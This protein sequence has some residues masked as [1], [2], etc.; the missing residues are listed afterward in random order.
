MVKEGCL[1]GIEEVYGFHNSPMFDEGF[2]KVKSGA[3]LASSSTVQ[4]KILGQGGHA[5]APM[6]CKD[7]ISCGA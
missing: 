6:L 3:I 4:M 2:I 7:V 5:S 1:D